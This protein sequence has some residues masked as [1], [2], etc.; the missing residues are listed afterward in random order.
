VTTSRGSEA[1]AFPRA[2]RRL[3]DYKLLGVLATG[4]MA[5]LFLARRDSATEG[6]ELLVIK[7]IVPA[8]AGEPESVVR[9]LDEARIAATLQH[10]NIV[11]SH[12]VDVV[13]GEVFLVM[14]F[15]HGQDVRSVLRRANRRGVRLPLENVVAE[16]TGA[17]SRSSTAMSR[18]TTSSSATTA[19][20]RSSI[21]ASPRR[22]PT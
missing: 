20:S 21:S 5:Q 8:L 16:P 3:K 19:A 4:G 9:F 22:R 1:A 18:L 10:A 15:L 12:E 6:D 11:R 14:E 7:R 13:D 2:A 17:R